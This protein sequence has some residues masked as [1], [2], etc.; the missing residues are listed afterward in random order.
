MAGRSAFGSPVLHLDWGRRCRALR[1][2]WEETEPH[3]QGIQSAKVAAHERLVDDGH[4]GHAVAIALAESAATAKRDAEGPEVARRDGVDRS[5]WRFG[6]GTVRA[7]DNLEGVAIGISPDWQTARRGGGYD[8]TH[9]PGLLQQALV[10]LI[11][12]HRGR[13][14]PLRHRKL[15]RQHALRTEPQVAR[16]DVTSA[17]TAAAPTESS[18]M[19]SAIS[20][21][22]RER[23]RPRRSGVT[24]RPPCFIASA[25][26]TRSACRAGARPAATPMS[27]DASTA[28]DRTAGS[29]RRPSPTAA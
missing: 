25:A 7:S 4:V 13:E 16:D 19:A 3:L 6:A 17:V 24:A 9:A 20:T 5:A 1:K 8:A 21:T 28:A 27:S 22:T 29:A 11:H 2:V 10:E 26:F 12:P 18:T 15:H 23:A 14:L